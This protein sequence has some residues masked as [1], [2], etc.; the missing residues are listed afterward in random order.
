MSPVIYFLKKFG[1]FRMSKTIIKN[2]F[3]IKNWKD[4]LLSPFRMM[5]FYARMFLYHSWIFLTHMSIEHIYGA[6]HYSKKEQFIFRL[7][8][9]P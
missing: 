6:G 9:I 1:Y 7:L 4:I 3:S 2:Y 8:W 5:Y